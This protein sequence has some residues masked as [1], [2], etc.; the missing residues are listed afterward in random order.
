MKSFLHATSLA[1]LVSMS[2]L[3]CTTDDVPA[4]EG[5]VGS[6]TAQVTSRQA[7]S[8]LLTWTIPTTTANSSLQYKIYLAGSL[9]TNNLSNNQFTLTG[10]LPAQTYTGA[11]VAFLSPDDSAVAHFSIPVFNTPVNP[12]SMQVLSYVSRGQASIGI[13]YDEVN[14][15][16]TGWG[17]ADGYDSTKIFYNPQGKV[18]AIVV[19]TPPFISNGIQDVNIFT[20]NAQGRTEKVYH[21][22][23][24]LYPGNPSW[25]TSISYPLNFQTEIL[26]VDSLNYN[27]AGKVVSSYNCRGDGYI[28]E[29]RLFTYHP[30]NDSLLMKVE[31]YT[32][33]GN[34]Y[35]S[36]GGMIV[37]SYTNKVNPY[38]ALCKDIPLMGLTTA[39]RPLIV[40]YPMTNGDFHKY[41]LGIPYMPAA[42]DG[43][44]L[45][46]EHWEDGSIKYVQIGQNILE[47]VRY[48]YKKVPR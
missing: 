30:T 40:P 48:F 28:N 8:V 24:Q 34:G 39:T 15:R 14:R 17:S 47:Y 27:A 46:Y 45:V 21:K 37:N 7:N 11:V 18:Q 31:W 22:Y 4:P 3:S 38:Y 20:Y 13:Y 43:L 32:N 35:M 25:L 1:I 26:S 10:L 6:F 9:I 29:Y 41:L 12:D 19:T 2:V 44:P 36:Q 33:N 42:I 23:A 16:V 5:E